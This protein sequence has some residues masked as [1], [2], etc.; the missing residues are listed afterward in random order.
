MLAGVALALGEFPVTPAQI[1]W[2]NMITAVTLALALAFEPAEPGIMSRPPRDPAAPLLSRFLVRRI[3]YVSVLV[4]VLCMV[5][6]QWLLSSGADPSYARTAVVNALVAAQLWYLFTCRFKWKASIGWAA[7]VG[8]PAA[9]VAAGLLLTFQGAFT[10]LPVAH[11]LFDTRPL[12]P[13]TWLPVLSVGLVLYLVVELE[14][15]VGRAG[16]RGSHAPRNI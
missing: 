11:L 13:T 14:K 1:L 9:L 3:V 8:N 4:A 5:L 6:F 16:G 10:Y 7:L 15:A 12:S 2:V